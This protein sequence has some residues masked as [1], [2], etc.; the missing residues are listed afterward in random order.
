[1]WQKLIRNKWEIFWISIIV[2]ILATIRIFESEIFYDPFISYFKGSFQSKSFPE[3]NQF[4]LF[5]SYLIRFV[6][7]SILSL[8][9]LKLVF[10]NRNFLDFAKY[11]YLLFFIVFIIAFFICYN[12]FDHAM[13]LFYIR[14]FI[15]QPLLLLLLL[16]GFYYQLQ[17]QK[18]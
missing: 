17:T 2:F 14:R 11:I 3:V 10:K 12:Y 18:K 16:A 5:F 8:I 4:L 1:M 15:I 13:I 6:I 7:N 9:V